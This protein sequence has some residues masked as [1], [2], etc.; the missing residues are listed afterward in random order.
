LPYNSLFFEKCKESLSSVLPLAVIVCILCFTIAPVG[1]DVMLAFVLGCLLLIVGLSLF[2]YGVER[3]MSKIGNAIGAKLTASRNLPLIIALSFVIGIMITV[4]EPDLNVLAA[5]VP[6]IDATVLIV[7]VAVG[8]GLFLVICMLRI[9]FQIPLRLLLIIS[10]VLLFVLAF[11]S[12]EN[13]VAVA[14]DSGGVTT[15]PMTSPFIIALGIGVASIRSDRRAED[16]SFGLLALCSIGPILAV[17]LLGFFYPGAAESSASAVTGSWADTVALGRS[18]IVAIPAYI[19]EVAKALAPVVI[20]FLLF[21][22][23]A[24]R[25][26]KKKFLRVLRGLLYTYVGLVLFLTGVNVGFSPLGTI[27][28]GV[29]GSGRTKYLLIPIFMLIGWFLAAA[30]PAVHVLTKQVEEISAG[31]VSAKAMQYSLSAAIS[32]AMGLSMLRILTGL[33]IFWIIVPGYAAALIM[34]F[35]VPRIFTAIAFDAGGVASGPMSA[36]F[37][38]PF[39]MGVSS[40][41]G[42]NILTDAFGTVALVA[43]MPLITVQFM[44]L[45]STKRMEQTQAAPSYGDADVIEL[46]G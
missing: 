11:L 45:V 12:D 38:L 4:A 36:T 13:Y 27:L 34:S 40:A 23:F 28:G 30:E 6:S 42:G 46:W 44:G 5:T 17:L 29:L 19:A 32:L 37:M 1:T 24:L 20:F 10:Y 8:V 25:F 14:F 9:L 2:M 26:P 31:A 33:E 35:F 41:I 7:T 21:Q 22:A 39:A 15:G 16:D 43:M 3:S 18:Y